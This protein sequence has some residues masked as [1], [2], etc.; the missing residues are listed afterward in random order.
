MDD[1]DLRE[2][3]T[4]FGL[5]LSE[6]DVFITLAQLRK[7]GGGWV[8]GAELAE[9]A[10][11]PRVRVYQII[12]A[13]VGLGLVQ[14][15]FGRPKEYSAEPPQVA[16][17]K[18]VAAQESKLNELAHLEQPAVEELLRLPPLEDGQGAGR[19]SRMSFNI[20]QGIPNIQTAIKSVLRCE[21]ASVVVNRQSVDQLVPTLGY[22]KDGPRSLRLLVTGG[23]AMPK[24]AR[25]IGRKGRQVEVRRL[26]EEM[27]TT[28]LTEMTFVLLLYSVESYRPK[29]LSRPR[30]RSTASYC[31]SVSDDSY[32]KQ[33]GCLFQSLWR[34][35]GGAS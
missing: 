3:L 8:S 29:P 34:S 33:A 16:M 22:L 28:V 24:Y 19:R 7:S 13:L 31:V 12:Q 27:P 26:A 17:R 5:T 20:V 10:G 21:G 25:R 14:A 2:L 11:K 18:L 1:G 6:A 32:L 35:A 23:A 9:L 4:K 30:D 15:S